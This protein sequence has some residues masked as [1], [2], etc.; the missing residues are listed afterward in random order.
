MAA[1]QKAAKGAA[2]VGT[3][4]AS[5]K[6]NPYVQRIIED[7]ELRDNVRDAYE[8]ARRAYGRISNGKA[9]TKV[10]LED[11]K[12]HKELSNTAEALRDASAALRGSSKRKR[13]G[14][15]GRLLLLTVVGAV[16][17]LVLSEGL[18]SKVLDL[19]FG[20]EEE[21]DYSSTTSPPPA[22]PSP[23]PSSA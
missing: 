16:L 12:L 17:A 8:S 11:K 19:L 10:L 2:T 6:A 3:A 20:A 1:K 7:G 18:R 13:S 15:I 4:Y 22:A 9:P 14:G 5:A 23:A 21:F